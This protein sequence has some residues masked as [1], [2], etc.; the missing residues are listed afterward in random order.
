MDEQ[1]D[2]QPKG[3]MTS[4]AWAAIGTIGAA[5]VAAL[6]TLV[7]FYLPA[8]SVPGGP[9]SGLPTAPASTSTHS[10]L[11]SNSVVSSGLDGVPVPRSTLLDELTG[12]WEWRVSAGGSTYNMTLDIPS[13]CAEGMPCGT[14]TTDLYGCVG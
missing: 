5:V 6:V 7:T 4:A 10:G 14:M 2:E 11:P 12:R 9:A 1:Q 3:G 8:R 13:T